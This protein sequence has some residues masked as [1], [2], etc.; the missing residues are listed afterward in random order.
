M[1]LIHAQAGIGSIGWL[2]VITVAGFFLLCLFR[3]GPHYLDKFTIDGALKSL[4]EQE[5]NLGDM[6]KRTIYRKLD[7]F[8]MINNVRGE[9]GKSF[10]IIRKK[11]KLLINNIYEK[12]IHMF[13]NID[14]VLTFKSQLDTSNPEE[15]CEYLIETE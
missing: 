5:V 6:E 15:C 9:E 10:K 3:L 11:D 14:V 7:S 4:A 1:K 12:R 8:M 2:L 13:S